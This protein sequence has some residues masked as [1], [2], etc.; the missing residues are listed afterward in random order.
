MRYLAG[1]PPAHKRLYNEDVKHSLLQE[2]C[3]VKLT[4]FTTV[5]SRT[6]HTLIKRWASACDRRVETPADS[7]KHAAH[8]L[9]DLSHRGRAC[10][11]EGASVQEPRAVYEALVG[12]PL[13]THQ[14]HLVR[15]RPV[16]PIK[17]R[18]LS[19]HLT[20]SVRAGT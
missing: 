6:S 17:V 13:T 11:E 19:Q 16:G 7:L 8:H 1:M 4:V 12:A 20:Q 5:A 18:M 15:E 14:Q 2:F 10:R 3:Q 9:K